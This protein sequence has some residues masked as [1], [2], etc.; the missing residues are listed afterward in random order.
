MSEWAL[1]Y[2]CRYAGPNGT[3]V[4]TGTARCRITGSPTNRSVGIV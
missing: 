1:E 4:L 3:T 2:G